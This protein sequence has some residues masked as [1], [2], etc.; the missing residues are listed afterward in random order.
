MYLVVT[1]MIY[2]SVFS[3][4][5]G[6]FGLLSRRSEHRLSMSNDVQ[7][8]PGLPLFLTSSLDKEKIDEARRLRLVFD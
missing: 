3:S 4:T 5:N 7:D 2:A 6:Y 8:D 1:M